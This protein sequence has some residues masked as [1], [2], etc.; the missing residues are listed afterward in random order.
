MIK[1]L[2]ALGALS[3]FA[4]GMLRSPMASSVDGSRECRRLQ[5][6]RNELQSK[7]FTPKN[8]RPQLDT[9]K[10][11]E[12]WRSR[13]CSFG[14]LNSREAR[15]LCISPETAVTSEV[16]DAL[17]AN[18]A[19]LA[20]TSCLLGV[21]LSYF[22]KWGKVENQSKMEQVILAALQAYNGRNPL[23]WRCR[24]HRLLV[25]SATGAK[26]L[27]RTVIEKQHT[28]KAMLDHFGIGV[29]TNLGKAALVESIQIFV[30]ILR[31]EKSPAGFERHLDYAISKLLTPDVA[32]E[33]FYLGV[34]ELILHPNGVDEASQR[35]L[36]E[37]VMKNDRLG[38]P[39]LNTG[40]WALVKP[41]AKERFLGW[42]AK[43]FI[44]FFFNHVLPDN[45]QNR[46][47]KDFWLRFVRQLVDFQVALSTLDRRRL[48]ARSVNG[49]IPLSAR[50]DHE[51]TSAFLMRFR[52]PWGN[53]IIIVEFSE[54]GN[55]AHKFGAKQ[56][57]AEAGTLRSKWFRFSNLK[58]ETDE[59]RILHIGDRWEKTAYDKMADWGIR[60]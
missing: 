46:R 17:H 29:T 42:I 28:H 49:A 57:E 60:C 1:S 19:I 6:I 14:S 20:K 35:K 12:L 41:E 56:F 33:S 11:W 32:P 47:R 53:E 5:D 26:N 22:A 50:V 8:L 58:H 24:E 23:L 59:N 10:V 40:N 16:V 31:Q 55:A 51:T 54:T 18:P 39:R 34:S 7:G 48:I 38:D 13:A 27:G 36:R 3:A 21:I 4:D 25:F 37:Y 45:N 2:E 30:S 43:E 9:M 15:I 52:G 44:V